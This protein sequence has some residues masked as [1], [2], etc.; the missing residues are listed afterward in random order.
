MPCLKCFFLTSKKQIVSKTASWKKLFR[1]QLGKFINPNNKYQG[2]HVNFFRKPKRLCRKHLCFNW[3]LH[4]KKTSSANFGV[5]A[6]FFSQIIFNFQR[7]SFC[8]LFHV[9]KFVGKTEKFDVWK[10]VFFNIYYNANY[11]GKGLNLNG[12]SGI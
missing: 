1:I 2:R 12:I 8:I 7:K 9:F 10:G 5:F 4:S 3:I 11:L 6:T